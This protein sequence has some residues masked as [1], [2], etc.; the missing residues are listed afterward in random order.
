MSIIQSGLPLALSVPFILAAWIAFRRQHRA[1]TGQGAMP[2]ATGEAGLA[3]PVDI[4]IASAAA[5]LEAA[6]RQAVE[7][8]AAAARSRWVRLELAVAM[9]MT[10]PMSPGVLQTALRDT[11]L[12]VIDAV[13]GGQVLVTAA[14]FGSHLHI[15]ITD[16]GPGKDQQVREASMR[17]TEAS[18]ALQGGSIIVEAQPGRGTS[19]L[20]RLPMPAAADQETSATMRVPFLVDQAA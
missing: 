3:D 7:S 2:D 15:C 12:T 18:I 4:R 1:S 5:D 16:D 8:V 6:L 11:L 13:P 10:V 9:R 14:T 20:I 17:Q 19:I